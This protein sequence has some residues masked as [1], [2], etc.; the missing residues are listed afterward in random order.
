MIWG[1]EEGEMKSY[2]WVVA[3]KPAVTLGSRTP[4]IFSQNLKEQEQDI[5]SEI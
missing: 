2:F 5:V 3:C 4:T 1:Q